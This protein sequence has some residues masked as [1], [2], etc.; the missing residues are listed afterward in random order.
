MVGMTGNLPDI[1]I[2]SKDIKDILGLLKKQDAATAYQKMYDVA[3]KITQMEY[4]D[5][6]LYRRGKV[7]ED[8][9]NSEGE[10]E[11]FDLVT[12]SYEFR[13][14]RMEHHMREMKELLILAIREFKEK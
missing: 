10:N 14:A 2:D 13:K 9:I 3:K 7:L 8:Q 6:V 11:K 4:Q 12:S 1:K 5:W